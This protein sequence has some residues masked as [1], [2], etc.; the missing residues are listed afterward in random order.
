MLPYALSAENSRTVWCFIVFASSA[1]NCGQSPSDVTRAAVIACVTVAVEADDGRP[2]FIVPWNDLYLI[3]TTDTRYQ[4]DLDHVVAS[5]EEI[6]YLIG[7]TNEVIPD[8]QLSRDDVIYTYAGVR[9]LP[10]SHGDES[11]VTGGV[12]RSSSGSWSPA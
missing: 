10:E 6:E 12:I 8:A 4:G 1:G 9:P 5:D 11:S 7:A 3:G 2:Y